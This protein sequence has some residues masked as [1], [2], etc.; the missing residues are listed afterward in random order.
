[1]R[2]SAWCPIVNG[3]NLCQTA[4]NFGTLTRSNALGNM[5]DVPEELTESLWCDRYYHFCSRVPIL[6]FNSGT[7]TSLNADRS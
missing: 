5:E 2:V 7:V 1:M 4:A 6:T 3:N